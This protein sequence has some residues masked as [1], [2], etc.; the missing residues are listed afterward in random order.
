MSYELSSDTPYDATVPADLLDETEGL[1]LHY[2]FVNTERSK[3]IFVHVQ[4]CATKPEFLIGITQMEAL[5]HCPG[6]IQ[7]GRSMGVLDQVIQA[8]GSPKDYCTRVSRQNSAG[9]VKC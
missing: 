6:L 3:T 2:N 5:F 8:G 7:E 4:G 9:V 1:V